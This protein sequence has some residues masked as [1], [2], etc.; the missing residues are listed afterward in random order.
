MTC[1][2]G[3]VITKVRTFRNDSD[4]AGNMWVQNGFLLLYEALWKAIKA[5]GNDWG[6]MSVAD[7][8]LSLTS[9]YGSV[10]SQPPL[11]SFFIKSLKHFESLI[12]LFEDKPDPS[13]K[14]L[15]GTGFQTLCSVIRIT[16]SAS[17]LL[18]CISILWGC[19]L[20]MCLFICCPGVSERT[21]AVLE[22]LV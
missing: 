9:S 10:S 2:A 22:T 14:S 11:L 18:F 6:K 20:G 19:G 12:H 5:V 8:W 15:E 17:S 4:S 3:K 16:W 1:C 13:S 7:M 21:D